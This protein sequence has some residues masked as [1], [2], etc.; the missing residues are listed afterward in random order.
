LVQGGSGVHCPEPPGSG[1]LYS[2]LEVDSGTAAFTGGIATTLGTG[3]NGGS[4]IKITGGT[5]TT[6]NLTL[7]RSGGGTT[8]NDA[9]DHE[10]DFSGN[11]DGVIIT[12]GNATLSGAL[13]IGSGT[14]SASAAMLMTGGVVNVAG[15][16][17]VANGTSSTINRGGGIRITGGAFTNTDTSTN[18]G[19][20]LLGSTANRTVSNFAMA[21]FAGGVSSVQ[22]VSLGA[23]STLATGVANLYVDGGTL[24]VGSG[25]I[26]RAGTATTYLYTIQLGG[27]GFAPGANV[28]EQGGALVTGFASGGTQYTGDGTLVH[29]AI[30]AVR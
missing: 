19:L 18:G 4:V 22:K 28:S 27:S 6:T 3:N 16:V 26:N 29:R 13:T 21:E 8:T 20:V 10:L 1:A 11:G 24:Y 23:D 15:K 9:T 30:G 7:A 2:I 12:G 5:V 14:S 25:G 17:I